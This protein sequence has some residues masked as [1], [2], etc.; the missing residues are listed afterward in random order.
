MLQ[1]GVHY[2][3]EEPKSSQN[4]NNGDS[5][6]SVDDWV[7]SLERAKDLA[8][9]QNHLAGAYSSDN[10]F[11]DMSSSMSSPAST[12]GG[13]ATFPEGYS[14]SDRSGRNQLSK[15]QASLEQDTPA[16]AVKRNRFSKRQSKNGLGAAF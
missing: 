16:S 14:I 7:E 11:G 4:N 1:N 6:F 5:K 15:S 2:T 12:M 3:F 8:L 10:G 9:S 13:R